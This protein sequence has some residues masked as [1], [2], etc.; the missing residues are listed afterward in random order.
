MT[1]TYDFRNTVVVISGAA[2]GQ[3]L[4]H[5]LYFARSGAKVIGFDICDKEVEGVPY[6]LTTREEFEG[7]KEKFSKVSPSP[8]LFEADVRSELEL[9]CVADFVAGEYGRLDILINNAGVSCIQGLDK[10]KKEFMDAVIDI[11]LKGV[12]HTTHAL[13]DLLKRS[14]SGRI[15]NIASLTT[16]LGAPGLSYYAASKSGILG[17][18]KAWAVEF[19]KNN[20]TVNSISPTLIQ[21]PQFDGLNRINQVNLDV[22]A[23]LQY[24]LPDFKILQ[25]EDMSKIILWLCSEDARYITG[26]NLIIDAGKIIK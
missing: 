14:D 19:G 16:Q 12:F 25:P 24:A 7:A 21:S 17:L 22:V 5:A 9:K 3:G 11:N 15:I 26:I 2:R 23:S 18:T 20:I 13:I 1:V 10:M 8:V 4:S 6:P